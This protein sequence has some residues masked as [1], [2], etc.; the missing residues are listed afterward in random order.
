MSSGGDGMPANKWPPNGY[1]LPDGS[2]LRRAVADGINWEIISA[3]RDRTALIIL[4]EL[5]HKWVGAG[6]ISADLFE[7]F[8]V[9]NSQFFLPITKGFTALSA[10][11]LSIGICGSSRKA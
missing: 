3:G 10:K 5:Y 11:L 6:L 8:D 7:R 1:P 2:T 9:E 4:P